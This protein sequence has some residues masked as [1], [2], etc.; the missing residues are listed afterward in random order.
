MEDRVEPERLWMKGFVEQMGFKSGV[1]G[2]GMTEKSRRQ[3]HDN[4]CDPMALKRRSW[5]YSRAV[6]VE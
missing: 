3:R 1:K 6:S 4:F 2:G 5:I